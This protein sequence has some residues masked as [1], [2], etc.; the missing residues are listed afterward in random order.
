MVAPERINSSVRAAPRVA[1][2]IALLV[3]A[4]VVNACMLVLQWSL[5]RSLFVGAL[6][7]Y[8]PSYFDGAHLK[9]T[10][11]EGSRFWPA[12][13]RWQGWTKLFQ[14]FPAA[15]TVEN[16]YDFSSTAG[17]GGQFVFACHPHGMLSLEYVCQEQLL[18]ILPFAC[19]ESWS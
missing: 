6:V 15:I 18:D 11:E 3:G 7:A 12:L 10:E 13:A 1:P 2:L 8:L 17:K 4:V 9:V 14:Y 19:C 5:L 16:K